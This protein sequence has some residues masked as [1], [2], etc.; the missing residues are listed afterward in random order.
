MAWHNLIGAVFGALLVGACATAEQKIA[1]ASKI[2]F[3]D[4]P[5]S[6][7]REYTTGALTRTNVDGSDVVLL[8]ARIN[9]KSGQT[10]TFVSV[11][12][13][14]KTLERRHYEHAA[15]GQAEALQVQKLPVQGGCD[16]GKKH[17]QFIETLH[18]VIPEAVLRQVSPAGYQFKIFAKLGF[19]LLV[20]LQ[21]PVVDSLLEKIDADRA[22]PPGPAQVSQREAH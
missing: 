14:Y 10:T 19:E 2:D 15:N 8:A 16:F 21:K 11:S 20:T 9:R 7:Y 1:A 3:R 13:I 5:F 22:H 12:I 6:A 17:C 18:V 4:D